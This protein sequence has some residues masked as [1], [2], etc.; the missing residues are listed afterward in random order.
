VCNAPMCRAFSRPTTRT[1]LWPEPLIVLLVFVAASCGGPG[2]TSSARERLRT[3][4]QVS[5]LATADSRRGTELLARPLAGDGL[6]VTVHRLD[7]GLTVYISPDREQPRIS[8]RIVV[9]V[10][11]R[12]DPPESTGLAHYLE[13]MLFKGT[14]ILG[15]LDG[16][17]EKPVLDRIQNLY[18][19]LYTERDSQRRQQLLAEIDRQT[20]STTPWIIPNELNRLYSRLGITDVNAFTASDATTF[21]ASLPSTR[22]AQWA[23]IE[24]ERLA[25]PSFRLFL[26][27]LEVVYEEKNEVLDSPELR[28]TEA[29]LAAL[30]PAHPYGTQTPIGRA[31]HLKNPAFADMVRHFERWYVPDNMAIVLAG[32]LDAEAA[33][34]ILRSTFG[35]WPRRPLPPSPPGDSRIPAGRQFRE[36]FAETEQSVNLGWRT[37][38]RDHDDAAALAVMDMLLD[39]GRSGMLKAD[40]V[41][42]GKVMRAGAHP[43]VYREAGAW[44]MA[45][46]AR[47]G[48]SLE[49]VERLLLGMVERVRRGDFDEHE[50][51]AVV[52]NNEIAEQ[53]RLETTDPRASVMA[54]AFVFDQRWSH[55]VNRLPRLRAVRKVDVVRVANRYLG[56]D[57]V[58]IY[59]RKGVFTPPKLTKVTFTPL[60]IDPDRQSAFAKAVEQAP[61]G[62]VEPRWAEQGRDYWRDRVPAGKLLASLNTRNRLFRLEYLFDLGSRRLPLICQALS[63]QRN[64]GAGDLSADLVQRQLFSFG[65]TVETSC[66]AEETKIVVEGTDANMEATLQLLDRWF[67]EPRFGEEEVLRL[68]ETTFAQRK[69]DLEDPRTCAE[70]LQEFSLRGEESSW[71]RVPS[72]STLSVARAEELRAALR[73]FLH[74]AH[75]TLYF[76]PRP[77]G[78]ASRAVALGRNH[79]SVGSR[80]PARMRPLSRSTIYVQ[81]RNL[82]QAQISVAFPG[83]PLRKQ[84]Q[85]TALVLS[86]Y[87]GQGLE[88]AVSQS[89][90][91]SEGLAY[92]ASASLEW[93]RRPRDA[94]ALVATLETETSKASRA[95]EQLVGLLRAARV[96]AARVSEVKLQLDQMLRASRPQPRKMGTLVDNWDEYGE[97]RDPRARL[98]ASVAAVQPQDLL[99]FWRRAAH[100]PFVI[101]VTG[102]RAELDLQRLA[103]LAPVREVEGAELFGYGPFPG[104]GGSAQ[105][106]EP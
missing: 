78:E 32:D 72:N 46:G 38:T 105:L 8:A 70:A 36:I 57:F 68:K 18:A 76:G 69:T 85:A 87:L 24:A 95:I 106:T 79:R 91:E 27:E 17:A 100:R 60:A 93:G 74:N 34:P 4:K 66:A 10:G 64:A 56:G 48:Q 39:N 44:M 2:A 53:V 21:I 49:E 3:G 75:K 99:D 102:N 22:F 30:Y 33:M 82:V 26:P 63:L 45:A 52:L 86:Q 83:G 35:R 84:D 23:R 67:H 9:R 94:S 40:L 88:G 15:T 104:V 90:R 54:N 62:T 81:N 13:H 16:T 37:V 20:Q 89:V 59:R 19:S 55:V 73:S 5:S 101:A 80:P 43:V 11:S 28:M 7:N 98:R 42:S 41:T 103:K 12:H 14:A 25:H 29:L 50:L 71:R 61:A 58:A 65:S 97:R 51:E 31:E 47:D 6:S 77:I 96:D 92:S 1:V